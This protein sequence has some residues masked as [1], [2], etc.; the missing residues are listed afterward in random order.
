MNKVI[1]LEEATKKKKTHK[2]F[3]YLIFILIII[4][5][6]YTIYLLCKNSTDTYMVETGT[7]ALDES[8]IGYI[9]RDETV[10]KGE[11][12]KN[13]MY[14]IVP[15]GEKAA[16]NQTV[17]RYYGNNEEQIKKEIADTDEKLQKALANQNTIPKT[18]IK[19]IEKQIDNKLELLNRETDIQSI[20]EYYKNIS[21]LLNK[22]ARMVGE[23]SP[24]GSYIKELTDQ[25]EKL[26]SE[27]LKSSEYMVTPKSGIISYRIDDLENILTIESAD[28]LTEESLEKMDIKTGKL[29]S[30]SNEGAKVIDN[31]NCYI[32]T[33]LDS[34]QAKE[35]AENT[36]VT[37]TLSNGEDLNA[38]IYKK[39]Q[40]ENG[41]MLIIL[42]LD[43]LIDEL[44]SY[45]KISFNITWWTASGLKIKNSSIVEDENGLKYV[46]RKKTGNYSKM[47]VKVLRKNEKYS[48]V[49]TYKDS[50]LE[51]LKVDMAKYIKISIYD[52]L[53]TYPDL[54]K[55]KLTN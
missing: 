54:T 23:L 55:I 11:N 4:Y 15:E 33:F 41:K 43:T 21:E 46:I 45:R 20:N 8:A 6:I 7:V 22:K 9:I 3:I 51:N 38:V 27:L 49:D 29:I 26:E 17:F 28:K 39:Y 25:R 36:N 1:N 12:Y 2:I 31:F 32:V 24:T 35:V 42:K 16:K 14:Q 52:K 48:I 13:G 19:N 5:I 34:D 30:A 37:I 40:Q 44:I 10:I 53:L 47:L 50:E 18:D